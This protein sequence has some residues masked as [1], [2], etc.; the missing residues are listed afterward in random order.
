MKVRFGPRAVA[1][2]E[3]VPAQVR[4]HSPRAAAA[5]RDRIEHLTRLLAT[6]PRMGQPTDEVNVHSPFGYRL[7][8]AVRP[9]RREVFVLRIIHSSRLR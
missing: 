1:Q 9:D 8:Y 7:F 6:T 3:D 4:Q 2:I 5:F